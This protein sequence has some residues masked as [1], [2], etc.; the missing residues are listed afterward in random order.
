MLAWFGLRSKRSSTPTKAPRRRSSLRSVLR[1]EALEDRVLPSLTPT[2]LR[3]IHP[4][5]SPPTLLTPGNGLVYFIADNGSYDPELWRSDGTAAGTILLRDFPVDPAASSYLTDLTKINGTLFFV[6][7]SGSSE[8][9][10]YESDGTP[11]GTTLVNSFAARYL[12]NLNGTLFFETDDP[13]TLWESD[14]ATAGQLVVQDINPGVKGS[15]AYDLTNVNG[16]L[17]FFANDA[18]GADLWRSD[19]TTT[20]TFPIQAIG[21]GANTHP[22]NLTNVNGTAFFSTGTSLGEE[23]WKSDGTTAGTVLVKD[24]S[25]GGHSPYL[26]YLTNVNG[27]LLFAAAGQSGQELWKSNGTASGT[28][29]VKDIGPHPRFFTNLNGTLF[30]QAAEGTHG[31]QLWRSNGA[32]AG[33]FVVKDINSSGSSFPSYLTNVNGTLF[34][35]ANDG[36]HG[37][38]LWQSNGAAAGTRLVKDI[39]PGKAGSDPTSLA[40]LNGTLFFQANNGTHGGELWKSNDA[41]AGTVL[42]A[43]VTRAPAG[44]YPGEPTN[45]NGTLF[46]AADDGIHGRELWR[47]NGTPAGTVLV[48]D[49]EP[50]LGGDSHPY[51]VTNVNGTLFFMANDNGGADIELWRSDGTAA[52]TYL[53]KDVFPGPLGADGQYGLGDLTSISGTLFFFSSFSSPGGSGEALW[54][55]NGTAAGTF[56]LPRVP[57]SS[58]GYPFF[59]NVNGR[60]F[61]AADGEL[62]KS[63]GMSAG[64]VP[65]SSIQQPD[66]MLNANG[67]LF[68]RTFDNELWKSNGTSAGTVRLTDFQPQ[69]PNYNYSY[70]LTNVNGTVF[71]TESNG[72]GERDLWSSNGTAAG[73]VLVKDIAPGQRTRYYETPFYHPSQYCANVNGTLFLEASDGIHGAELWKSN[74]TPAGT[75][76]V[77]DINPGAAGSSPYWLTNVD[78][79]LFFS[80]YDSTHGDE[81]WESNGTAAGTFLVKDIFPGSFGSDPKYLANVNGILFFRADDGTHGSDAWVFAPHDHSTT[82]VSFHSGIHYYGTPVTITAT[83]APVV[84]SG[85]PTGTVTFLDGS[86]T[87]ATSVM[88][89]GAGVATFS[90]STLKAGTHRIT[91]VYSGDT[92][93]FGSKSASANLTIN[94][95]GPAKR[96][97][98]PSEIASAGTALSPHINRIAVGSYPGR[99][100]NVSGID[101]VSAGEDSLNVGVLKGVLLNPMPGG[102]TQA[103]TDSSP[104]PVGRV[105]GPEI[106]TVDEVFVQR[107][108]AKSAPNKALPRRPAAE[109]NWL[110]L[111]F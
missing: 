22:G 76:Q 81:L 98:D 109:A 77:K 10:L 99:T 54:E 44:S 83:V 72:F 16:T 84:D 7:E 37:T 64:T 75:F 13:A 110:E 53:V 14:G 11:A 8:E 103:K 108:P 100:T 97:T 23:L 29:L 42:V 19:G 60:V 79:T 57:F 58:L 106:H 38:E 78:G 86:T 88:L 52:G 93:C 3:D 73:T 40:N 36:T 49:I 18:H 17:F 90:T 56:P 25:P 1:A 87:L 6:F 70:S 48:K 41:P 50:G 82:T 51:D 31:A 85:T 62:W 30:F 46:F 92:H 68:F 74:G 71:F 67:T 26:D 63:N 35:S 102:S 104:G 5:G 28:L 91:A 12:T 27:T 43:D 80:A 47:T 15:H 9:G 45:V 61:F 2:L 111:W 69:S 39:F 24:V 94:L 95:A 59:T 32:S 20:G 96:D 4:P 21:S 65:V 107:G 33:T 55:S 101:D 89:N 105:G 34:F 66:Y